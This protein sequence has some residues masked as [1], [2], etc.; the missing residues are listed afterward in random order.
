MKTKPKQ[1][2]KCPGNKS[3]EY[4]NEKE[5]VK[6]IERCRFVKSLKAFFHCKYNDIH[7]FNSLKLKI[8]HEMKCVDKTGLYESEKK[9]PIPNKYWNGKEGL[10][11]AQRREQFAREYSKLPRNND[12]F[13]SNKKLLPLTIKATQI[14]QMGRLKV[15]FDENYCLIENHYRHKDFKKTVLVRLYLSEEHYDYSIHFDLSCKKSF[16]DTSIQ[17]LKSKVLNL[18]TRVFFT[19]LIKDAVHVGNLYINKITYETEMSNLNTLTNRYNRSNE[20]LYFTTYQGKEE[21]FYTIVLN[22]EKTFFKLYLKKSRFSNTKVEEENDPNKLLIDSQNQYQL[23]TQV[24]REDL[25]NKKDDFWA[26]PEEKE[27]MEMLKR[28]VNDP[29]FKQFFP[30]Y[31]LTPSP[32]SEEAE[33]PGFIYYDKKRIK[34]DTVSVKNNSDPS[35]KEQEVLSSSLKLETKVELDPN[36]KDTSSKTQASFGWLVGNSKKSDLEKPSI[37]ESDEKEIKKENTT[38]EEKMLDPSITV[39]KEADMSNHKYS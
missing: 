26:W 38:K 2:L 13:R 11:S 22:E 33:P 35:I 15:Y 30:S 8:A 17:Q 19:N 27:R 18:N 39:K 32:P 9:E 14:N 34:K 24:K 7:L 23:D 6:H 1:I 21:D 28:S 4:T 37:S 20:K 3:H 31:E 12:S 36:L 29:Y 16:D 25:P 5:F 10:T